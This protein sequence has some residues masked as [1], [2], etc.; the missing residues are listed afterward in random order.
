[1]YVTDR[2]VMRPGALAKLI[3]L[4]ERQPDDVI[5]FGDDMIVDYREPVTISERPWTGKLLRID[6]DQLLRVLARGILVGAP[7]MLN[8][9]APR[10]VMENIGDTYGSVFA[11]IA[12]DHCF[13]YRCLDRVDSIL[14]WDS[15]R[16][17]CSDALSHS[18]GLARS[19]ESA[20]Q[21]TLTSCASWGRLASTSTHLCRR[22]S[23]SRMRSTTNTS[24]FARR[25]R[26]Q[27]SRP[28]AVT[29]TWVRTPVM[30]LDWRTRT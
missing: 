9:V 12:P 22:C 27:N 11:S 24:S 5:T 16:S 13:S 2:L 15:V 30:W 7:T 28:C 4:A 6:S 18:N 23:P 10:A 29:T 20:I 17:S 8:T 14:H 25:D 21:P 1:M 3:S 26:P 19:A